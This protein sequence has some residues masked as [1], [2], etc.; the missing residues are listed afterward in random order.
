MSLVASDLLL[1]GHMT[2]HSC[3][4]EKLSSAR[5]KC[6]LLLVKVKSRAANYKVFKV[7]QFIGDARFNV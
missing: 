1:G 7:G 5:H 4:F 6:R 2:G 3:H